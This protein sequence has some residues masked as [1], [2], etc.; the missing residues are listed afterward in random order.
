MKRIVAAMIGLGAILGS[1]A[2]AQ[3]RGSADEAVALVKKTITA[4]KVEGKDKVY[5]AI[6]GKDAR[7]IDRDLYVFAYDLDA[8]CLAHGVNVKMVGRNAIETKDTDGKYYIKERMELGRA[9]D[10]FWQDYKFPDPITKKIEPKSAYCE[11][12]DANLICVGIYK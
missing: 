9:K 3:E 12:Y 1:P 7:Y 2:I 4:M 8:N 6:N 10:S 5:A 11:K